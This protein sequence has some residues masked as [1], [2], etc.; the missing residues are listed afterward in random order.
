[1]FLKLEQLSNS[2]FASGAPK[3]HNYKISTLWL[4]KR[5]SFS[6]MEAESSFLEVVWAVLFWNLWKPDLPPKETKSLILC[7]T[8]LTLF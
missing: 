7:F 4:G 5:N 6:N 3:V 1:M 8:V 2:S